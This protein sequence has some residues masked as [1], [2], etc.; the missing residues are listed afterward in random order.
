M[1]WA[2]KIGNYIIGSIRTPDVEVTLQS[3]S[4]LLESALFLSLEEVLVPYR[5][6]FIF[7]H[8]TAPLHSAWMTNVFGFNTVKDKGS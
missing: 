5:W 4:E 7:M 6:Q 3:Y 1:V 8:D 2:G